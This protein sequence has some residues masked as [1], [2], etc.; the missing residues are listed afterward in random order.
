MIS[1]FLFLSAAGL[2]GSH[3]R[4]WRS[5]RQRE[6][7]PI[8][9]D[10]RWRQF[11][12]RMQSSAMLGL[13]AVAIFVGQWVNSPPLAPVAVILFWMGALFLVIWLALLAV[14]D[15]VSTKHHFSRLRRDCLVERA[16]LQ[17]ELHRMKNLR[18]NGRAKGK[19]YQ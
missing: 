1:L 12:R 14:A 15:I 9:L 5:V 8:E 16:K 4:T 7:E 17:A 18:S 13:L 2:T 19:K 11:R 10:Y 3:V 6:L